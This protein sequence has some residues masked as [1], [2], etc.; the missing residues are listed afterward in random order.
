MPERA[1]GTI[2][3]EQ[4]RGVAV[5]EGLL[6]DGRVGER[7]VEVGGFQ[8]SFFCGEAVGGTRPKCS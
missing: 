5:L 7:I 1:V 2:E 6:G 4:A 3:H 8:N